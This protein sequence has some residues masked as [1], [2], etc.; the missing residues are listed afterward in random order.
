MTRFALRVSRVKS[1]LKFYWHCKMR[2]DVTLIKF[3]RTDLKVYRKLIHTFLLSLHTCVE[4]L[5][6]TIIV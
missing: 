5:L 2:R 3:K 4:L 1:I 6:T